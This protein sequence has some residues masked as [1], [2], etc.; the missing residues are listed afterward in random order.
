MFSTTIFNQKLR[1]KSIA[2]RPPLGYIYDLSIARGRLDRQHYL[3]AGTAMGMTRVLFK[4]GVTTITNVAASTNVGIMFTIIVLSLTD[5]GAHFFD[6]VLGEERANKL[7]YVFQQQLCY[8][9]VVD[10]AI[11]I[12]LVG[13]R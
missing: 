13:A 8:W 11:I 9:D 7:R 10:I 12:M 1:N 5:K 3:T 6:T 4:D 2:W